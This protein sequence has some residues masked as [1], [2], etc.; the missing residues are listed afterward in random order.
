MNFKILI[1]SFLIFLSSPLVLAKDF[2]F[3]K[4]PINKV[5]IT[6]NRNIPDGKLK[7]LLLTKQ[8]SWYNT[9]G[10]FGRRRISKT[11]LII[12]SRQ[13]KRQYGREGFLFAEVIYNT[14]YFAQD[15]SEVIANF[16]VEEGKKVIVDSLDVVGGIPELNKSLRK[17]TDKVKI[18]RAVNH[19]VV[20]ATGFRIRDYY[21]DNGYPVTK[22]TSEYIFSDDSS[23]VVARYDI[24]ESCYV[25]NGDITI[26]REG[27]P[28]TDDRVL[29]REVLVKSDNPYNRNLNYESQQRLY[30]TGLLKYVALRRAD[31]LRYNQE[32]GRTYT[33]YRLVINERKANF[34]NIRTG[35][36]RDPDFN[37]VFT[38]SLSWGNRSLWGT[39]RKLILNL[40]N[41]LRLYR[42]GEQDASDPEGLSLAELV[43]FSELDVEPVK[44]SI[45]L[46]YIEPWFL[47]H[48]LPL[49]ISV[50]YEPK[51]KNPIIKKF[52]DGLV[53]ETSVARE[54]NRFTNMR[55]SVRVEFVDIHGIKDTEARDYRTLGDNTIRRRLSFYGQRDTRDNILVP[56]R[57]S[58][59]YVSVDY[60]GHY[61]GG[62][63]SYIRGEFYWSRFQASLGENMIASRFRIGALRELGE[64][65]ADQDR[66]SPDDRFTLGGANTVR[67]F[68]E[69]SMGLLWDEGD[70]IDSTN[71]LYHQ[72]KGGRLLLLANLE[73]RRPLFWRFGG[74]AFVDVGNVFYHI[75]DFKLSRIETT[76]GLGFHFFTPIGPIRLDGAVRVKK[77]FDLGDSGYHLTILYAF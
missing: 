68:G 32:V 26:V 50:L 22:I 28:K 48:R 43:K 44:N 20:M 54:L 5:E 65:F 11:N 4:Q 42:P 60:V 23:R 61:L 34:I 21:A 71:A 72:P 36:E 40:S 56:Q 58:Y 76:A 63:F 2:K 31:T 57:G 70:E 25:H 39:G 77:K 18:N 46:N 6:G 47:N 30:S 41:S 9:W 49:S 73:L 24:A 17:I 14:D 62:D 35:V 55:F 45:G 52:Y 27:K 1:I 66:S 53:G 75:D 19:D 37:A 3:L 74:A 16:I 67:G 38:T 29:L 10:I 64:D 69:N 59:S 33:D 51:N 15:S 12:D 7:G 8:N 13:I